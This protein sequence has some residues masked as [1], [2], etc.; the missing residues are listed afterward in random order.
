MISPSKAQEIIQSNIPAPRE[1]FRPLGKTLGYWTSQDI[2]SDLS[3]PLAHQSAMDGFIIR[4]KDTRAAAPEHPVSLE[5]TGC[6][7]AGDP[8]KK[9]PPAAVTLR[10]MTGAVLPDGGDSI[11]PREEAVIKEGML[12]IK[13]PVSSWKHVRIKGEE[14]KRG[15]LLLPSGTLVRPGT[16]ALLASIGKGEIKIFR[17]PSVS[18]IT[19]GNELTAPGRKLT[20][21]KIYDS[22]SNMMR[23]VLDQSGF[24]PILLCRVK[25]HPDQLKKNISNALSKTD[26]LLLTGGVSVGDYDY[27]KKVLKEC[28]VQSLFWRIHQKPGK[29][30]FLGRC[31]NTLVF[32]LPG[33]PAAVFIC[34]YEYV[35]PALKK[36]SG[37][38]TEIPLTSAI[39]QKETASDP[40][41]YLFLKGKTIFKNEAFRTLPLPHQGS[42][43]VSSLHTM[44]SIL[45]IEPGLRKLKVGTKIKVRLISN[46]G[47]E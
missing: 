29:P 37:P 17:K 25:D 11:I 34:F 1:E 32:G 44:N 5:I 9:F 33:N 19:T 30:L 10:I 6:I 26:V 36:M 21:G 31:K 47:T 13:H 7:K 41:K 39:L 35:L 20:P 28:G 23:A 2:Y 38:G 27:V 4:A 42:H 16:I 14:L 22:N 3:L 46:F 43:M 40:K 45:H 15:D 12:L 24:S 18:V 8:P